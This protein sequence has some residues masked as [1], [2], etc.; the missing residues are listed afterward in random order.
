MLCCVVCCL[1]ARV[2]CVRSRSPRVH[3]AAA[4][5]SARASL[6]AAAVVDLSPPV[7]VARR[8]CSL[9]ARRLPPPK[10]TAMRTGTRAHADNKQRATAQ[11]P[12]QRWLQL[13][14]PRLFQRA[15]R[16][17]RRRVWPPAGPLPGRLCAR[18]PR[19]CLLRLSAGR[20]FFLFFGGGGRGRRLRGG[21][22]RARGVLFEGVGDFCFFG[23][24]FF[25]VHVS[26]R[27]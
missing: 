5:L 8:R 2:L 14:R 13:S 19:L 27:P 11:T 9:A 25:R 7:V 6:V 15:E 12:K 21:R 10:Q 17:R 22:G 26:H 20:P 1:R 24:F 18:H 3:A 16:A 23:T 4:V